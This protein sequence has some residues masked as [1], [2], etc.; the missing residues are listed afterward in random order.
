MRLNNPL[1]K[2]PAKFG[3]F[4]SA[5]V[6]VM[7]LVFYFTGNNPLVEMEMFDFFI[8]PIFL[9]FGI[10]EFKDSYNQR[11][12]E[13]WQ[14]MTAGFVV[15]TSIAVITSLF[16]ILFLS[17]DGTELLDGYTADRMAILEEQ[18]DGI[19]EEMGEATYL[20]SQ[21]DIENLSAGDIIFDNFLKKMFTGLLLTIMIAVIMRKKPTTDTPDKR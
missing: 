4:G 20:Q 19:V 6:I 16:L 12:L 17:L 18:K 5:M 15:Y 7:F 1:I 2:V 11:L 8:I 3:A 13:Y 9:F 14:G 21:Q 10:K